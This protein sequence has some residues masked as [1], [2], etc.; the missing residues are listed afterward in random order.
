[1]KVNLLFCLMLQGDSRKMVEHY[2]P[3]YRKFVIPKEINVTF[4]VIY[5]TLN[6]VHV[7]N[8]NMDMGYGVSATL[9]N[10]SVIS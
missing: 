2:T 4:N 9:N 8:Y 3:C 10:I 6:Q 1:M 5:L 7:I